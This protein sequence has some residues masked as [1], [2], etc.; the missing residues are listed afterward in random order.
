ME[1]VGAYGVVAVILVATAGYPD[2]VE[3][4]GVDRVVRDIRT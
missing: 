4:L 3:W 1:P 2:L